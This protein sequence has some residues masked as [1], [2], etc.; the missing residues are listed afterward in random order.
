[1]VC[2]RKKTN[3]PHLHNPHLRGD[4]FY[5]YTLCFCV[6]TLLA[7]L[8]ASKLHHGEYIILEQVRNARQ[9]QPICQ[10]STT[11]QT[12]SWVAIKAIRT[13]ECL[14]LSLFSNILAHSLSLSVFSQ[15]LY[16][17]ATQRNT[18]T[19]I[20]PSLH[21][22]CCIRKGGCLHHHCHHFVEG[23]YMGIVR[24]I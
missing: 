8:N 9:C 3:C 1:M 16:I 20:Q 14:S 19:V 21:V 22:N 4:L 23:I 18:R 5:L 12:L 10:Q 2:K 6:A 17:A 7:M 11:T 15:S 24:C 13:A